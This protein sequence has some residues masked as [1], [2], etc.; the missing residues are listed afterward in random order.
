[1]KKIKVISLILLASGLSIY[2]QL[3][4]RHQSSQLANQKVSR[5]ETTPEKVSPV[6]SPSK[7][8]DPLSEFDRQDSKEITDVAK[9]LAGITVEKNPEL[10]ILQESPNWISY[11]EFMNSAWSKLETK[12]LTA[13]RQWSERELKSINAAK[14]NIFYP[15]SGPDFLYADTFFDRAPKYILAGLE[16]IGLI[17]KISNLTQATQQLQ[18][19]QQSLYTLL[20]YSFF[21]T[22]DMRSDLK[23]NGVLPLLY[24]FLARTNH[25]L[26][27]VKYIGLNKE[28]QLIGL[29][30]PPQIGSGL[31]PGVKISFLSLGDTQP[32]TLY[33]FAVDLSNSELQK[34]PEFLEFVGKQNLKVTY[35]K[36]ASY[37]MHRETFSS[38]RNFILE[39][40]DYVLQDD[41]GIPVR[42][43]EEAK[44]NRQFYGSYIK[45]I[46][47]FAVRYQPDLRQIY[48]SNPNIKN[49]GFGIGYKFDADANL[50]LSISKDQAANSAI[51]KQ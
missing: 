15:F 28:G 13:A 36:A 48:Q 40:S 47:L 29:H 26:L 21:R 38:I 37:L 4:K 5:V 11:A 22:I 16:P 27:E 42:Y 14:M 34:T 24:V 9:F 39:H 12:Q 30:Q 31:I 45:P 2:L 49:L 17:P 51:G 43:F 1:M 25:T 3:C 7:P 46:D 6:V 23:D 10:S 32:K 8:I 18:G 33:Y 50:M 41:S 19:V 44:W 35:L 20:Q